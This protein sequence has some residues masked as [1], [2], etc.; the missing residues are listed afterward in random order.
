MDGQPF[1]GLLFYKDSDFFNGL[2]ADL[3][4]QTAG[5]QGMMASIR[6]YNRA[7]L[8]QLHLISPLNGKRLL[9]IGCAPQGYA[10]ERA[11]ELGAS[12]Y[13]GIGLDDNLKPAK[14]LF[15]RS[16]MG[17]LLH[18]DGMRAEF[19]DES[20]DVAVSMSAFEHISDPGLALAEVF[21]LLVPGGKLLLTFEPVWTCSYG[22]HLHF[23]GADVMSRIQP[24]SHLFMSPDEFLDQISP[25]WNHPDFSPVQAVEFAYRGTEINRRPLREYKT[26][27]ASG[28]LHLDWLVELTEKEPDLAAARRAAERLSCPADELLPIGLSALLTKPGPGDQNEPARPP[29]WRQLAGRMR[30]F[31]RSAS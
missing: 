19:P 28:P 4:Q 12:L 1:S 15:G 14:C 11:L 9:D 18:M 20:F 23:L 24:W 10:L 16:G 2:A 27:L 7:I 3:K 30:R 8:D 6:A 5:Y 22:H 17:L 13:A 29:G 31:F 25:G 21:R 26:L